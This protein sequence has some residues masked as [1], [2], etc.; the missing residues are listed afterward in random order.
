MIIVWG[1]KWTISVV[2]KDYFVCPVCRTN[3]EYELKRARKFFTFFWIPIIPLGKESFYIDCCYCGSSFNTKLLYDGE[4]GQDE[5]L[6]D[7]ELIEE[8]NE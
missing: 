1:T 4:V 7:D 8:E 3:Q 5:E 2:E 6:E